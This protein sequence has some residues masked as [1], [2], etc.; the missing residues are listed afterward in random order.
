MPFETFYNLNEKKKNNILKAAKEEFEAFKYVDASINRIIKAANISRGSFYQYFE[1]KND[2]YQTIF[3]HYII[4]PF[5]KNFENKK[6][7]NKLNIFDYTLLIF[8]HLAPVL[9][10]DK[11]LFKR[12]LNDST[13]EQIHFLFNHLLEDGLFNQ[14]I[15]KTDNLRFNTSFEKQLLTQ[16]LESALFN[17]LT[18]LLDEEYDTVRTKLLKHL[19][20]LK[21]GFQK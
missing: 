20:M 19:L 16:T 18:L 3:Y 17:A 6:I 7:I 11:L 12:I 1:D 8:M 5:R 15:I 4:D 2:L 10:Q 14:S 13:I 9:Q 21:I